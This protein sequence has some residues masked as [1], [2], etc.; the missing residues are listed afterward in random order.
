MVKI[1]SF[2]ERL[3]YLKIYGGHCISYSTLQPGMRYLD[4]P[5]IGY[6]AYMKMGKTRFV[7]GDPICAEE[8]KEMLISTALREYKHTSFY[9]VSKKTA[10]LLHK[11]FGFYMNI[12]GTEANIYRNE[13]WS[14]KLENSALQFKKNEL[15]LQLSKLVEEKDRIYN[16][17]G[18]NETL[19][20]NFWKIKKQVQKIRSWL[21]Q[22]NEEEAHNTFLENYLK[23]S[24]AYS[25]RRQYSAG[26]T[27]GI[28]IFEEDISTCNKYELID[29]SKNWVS[30]R[31]V[32]SNEMLFFTRPLNLDLDGLNPD[33]KLYTAKIKNKTIGFLILDPIYKNNKIEGYFADI[34]RIKR[35]A[36]AGTATLLILAS[37]N[38]VFNL[39]YSMFTLGL[40]PF[41]KVGTVR[42]I[43]KIKGHVK[44]ADN[45][46]MTSLFRFIFRYGNF[47]YNARDQAFH[48][49]RFNG[50]MEHTYCCTRKK[51]PVKE[52]IEGFGVSG[53]NPLKQLIRYF[54]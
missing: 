45:Q 22:I 51:F 35:D 19:K 1:F 7:L 17:M 50:R 34:L 44:I 43:N 14:G 24:E 38:D 41:H 21:S 29:I 40:S 52:I 32:S 47:L 31:M 13:V 54:K 16:T 4:L 20:K 42:F 39:N 46:I 53:I 26:L 18:N 23:R 49:E 11:K 33:V 9:Q 6:I 2:E 15:Q 36:P 37:M 3:N 12:F 27:S 28:E 48:K 8:N 10:E 30:T 5:G 25:L